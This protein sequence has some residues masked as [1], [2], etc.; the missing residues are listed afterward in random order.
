[1]ADGKTKNVDPRYL[2][3]AAAYEREPELADDGERRFLDP[4]HSHC[5]ALVWRD[6]EANSEESASKTWG[7][8]SPNTPH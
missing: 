3:D 8:R 4:A 7:G 6:S 1:V 2:A 5:S